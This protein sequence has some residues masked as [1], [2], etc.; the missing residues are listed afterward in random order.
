[1]SHPSSFKKVEVSIPVRKEAGI[2]VSFKTMEVCTRISLKRVEAG[3][4]PHPFREGGGEHPHLSNLDVV[5][6]ISFKMMEVGI[7]SLLRVWRYEFP[8]LQRR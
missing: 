6:P 1:M 8:S 5:I 3:I 4:P 2:P 7:P